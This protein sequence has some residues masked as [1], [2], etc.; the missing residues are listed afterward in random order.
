MCV[1]VCLCVCFVVVLFGEVVFVVVVVF[2][3]C[4]YVGVGWVGEE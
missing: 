1:F 2:V 4:E 3:D